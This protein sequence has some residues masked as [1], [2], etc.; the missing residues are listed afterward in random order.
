[1]PEETELTPPKPK[2][3]RKPSPRPAGRPAKYST[4]VM[5]EVVPEVA[6]E[7]G[8]EMIYG[9][10]VSEGFSRIMLYPNASEGN[11]YCFQLL[12]I[13]DRPAMYVAKNKMHVLPNALINV[14]L[15][16]VVP[17]VEDD[18][19]DPRH[20]VR[21]TAMFTRVPHSDPTPATKEDFIAYRKAQASLEHPNTYQKRASAGAAII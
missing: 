12:R 10:P 16:T 18:V 8:N 11:K 2:A 14:I 21:R 3:K 5:P 9:Y 13:G 19:S 7:N 6:V 1:M 17:I 15:D 20:P 4:S